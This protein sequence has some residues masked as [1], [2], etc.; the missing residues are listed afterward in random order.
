[1]RCM[2]PNHS[3]S[4]RTVLVSMF[5]VLALV[6]LLLAPSGCGAL[7]RKAIP[8][9]SLEAAQIPGMADVRFWG[10]AHDPKID[11][12][13]R[14]SIERERVALKLDSV[15]ELPASNFLALSG[16]GSNGAFGAG[17]LCGWTKHGDRPTFKVV[18][19]IS[20]GALIA[21]FAFLGPE[22][23]DVLREV[24]TSVNTSE[25]ARARGL[26][27]GLLGDGMADTTPLHRLVERYVTKEV[28]EKVGE[29]SKQGRI[30]IIGT[31]HMDAQRPIIWSMGRIARSGHPDALKLFRNVLI[32]SASIPGAF[33]PVMIE[34][35]ADGERYDEM[36]S[37]GGVCSQVFLYPASFS[38]KTIDAEMH[39]ERT[40]NVYVIRNAQLAAS[41]QAVPRRTLPIAVRSIDTLIK[42]QGIG[43]LY[44][45]YLGCKRDGLAYHLAYIPPDF[46]AESKEAFDPVYMT[47]LFDVGFKLGSDGYPWATAPPGFDPPGAADPHAP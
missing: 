25:I 33:P 6:P 10:D 24:Y 19:G 8:Q 30:L 16:G 17:L 39:T 28:M 12:A 5:A 9:D 37:D 2:K 3:G 32:A 21:P 14:S 46:D 27:D 11:L 44:R 15:T 7:P 20:T 4:P 29:A 41:Y 40:R 42:T 38:F 22:Y 1:M 45:I 13:F 26:L 23:D 31:T 47:K 34:V 35:E 36:H 18:T 43:D